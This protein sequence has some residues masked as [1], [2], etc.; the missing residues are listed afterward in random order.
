MT[1]IKSFH[2][3]A[4]IKLLIDFEIVYSSYF[5]VMMAK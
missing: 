2:V 1:S 3:V 5:V 4:H